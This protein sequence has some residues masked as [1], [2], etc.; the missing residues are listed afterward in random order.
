[1]DFAAWPG[2][3]DTPIFESTMRHRSSRPRW[4]QQEL[5]QDWG[6]DR[7]NWIVPRRTEGFCMFSQAETKDGVWISQSNEDEGVFAAKFARSLL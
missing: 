7:C 4:R 6:V 1:M 2:G 5:A 3:E